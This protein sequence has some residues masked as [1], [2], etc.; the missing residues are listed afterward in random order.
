[1]VSINGEKVRL[2]PDLEPNL[3]YADAYFDVRF[4]GVIDRFVDRAGL[5]APADDRRPF[6]FAPPILDEIDLAALG[7]NSVLWTSG[8]RMDYGWVDL[9]IF[10]DMGYPRHT[11]G[12]TEVPG[13]YF[14][15]LLWQRNQSSATLFGVNEDAHYLAAQMGIPEPT[16][17][18]RLPIPD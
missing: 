14:L 1:M 2:A 8:F 11:R 7:V 6:E 17:D 3:V 4:R 18:W 16:I 12:V 9:P 10:D 13:L 5:N 15:G